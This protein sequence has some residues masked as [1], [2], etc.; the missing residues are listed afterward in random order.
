MNTTIIYYTANRERFEH[1]IVA[2]LLSKAGKIPIVSV[3]QKPMELGKNICIGDV[4]YSYLN[5]RK[6][7]LMAAETAKTEYVVMAESDFLY[8]WN[9]FNFE[10]KDANIY[11]YKNVWIMWL[12]DQRRINFYKKTATSDGAQIVKRRFLIDLLK[13]YLAPYPGW[14]RRNN[15]N[16][17]PRHSPYHHIDFE[18]IDSEIPCVSIKSQE[19]LT[20]LTGVFNDNT[21]ENLPYWGNV[22]NLRSKFLT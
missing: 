4:G 6:Q 9:Y 17:D 8:P 2:D 20:Y 3:S 18:Y 1:K 5:E 13:K 12:N 19:G 22:N 7:I 21:K 15:K 16:V 11:R 10:P 14:Y